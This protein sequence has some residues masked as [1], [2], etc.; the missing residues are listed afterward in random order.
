MKT[1]APHLLYLILPQTRPSVNHFSKT[2]ARHA[3]IFPI[4][5][6]FKKQ[7]QAFFLQNHCQNIQKQHPPLPKNIHFA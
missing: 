3:H 4:F 6:T 5:L 7:P 1:P 2:K